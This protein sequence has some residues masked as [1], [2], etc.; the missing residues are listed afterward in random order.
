LESVE[1]DFRVISHGGVGG[2]EVVPGRSKGLGL[3]MA[4]GGADPEGVWKRQVTLAIG[5]KGC[6][7][8]AGAHSD[9]LMVLNLEE[10]VD[11]GEVVREVRLVP[12]LVLPLWG[13]ESF[14]CGSGDWDG[15]VVD[16]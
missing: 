12:C 5:V 4:A 3:V 1:H 16:L 2:E 7:L 15:V 11:T 6:N 13:C 8:A 10:A 9:V 14:V